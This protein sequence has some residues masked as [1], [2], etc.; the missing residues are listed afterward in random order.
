MAF[1]QEKKAKNGKG[2]KGAKGE[3]AEAEEESTTLADGV[4]KAWM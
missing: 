4:V 1:G 3:G 2:S